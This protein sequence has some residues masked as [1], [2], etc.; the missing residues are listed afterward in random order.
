MCVHTEVILFKIKAA[1]A[2]LFFSSCDCFNL[3]LERY[4]LLVACLCFYFYL[5]SVFKYLFVVYKYYV[6]PQ[7]E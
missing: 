5:L 3:N 1:L 4:I 6:R 2:Y 7:E